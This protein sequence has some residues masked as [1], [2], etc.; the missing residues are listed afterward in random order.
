MKMLY[1]L[2]LCLY[3]TSMYSQTSKGISGNETYLFEKATFTL[4]NYNS[5]AE[6]NTRVITDPGLVTPEDIFYQNVFR[7]AIINNG[8]LLYC[9]LPDEKDYAVKDD[10]VKLLA[11][12]VQVP[13]K[14]EKKEP[15]VGRV[16]SG[17]LEPYT[18]SLKGGVLTISVMYVYG[19]SRYPYTLEGKL[20][21]TMI[22][23]K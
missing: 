23:Q 20:V 8:S 16:F 17:Q 19:D 5:K 6:V 21:L 18:M 3:T 10:G 2:M 9:T 1:I 7:R 15:T 14:E 4:Y 11:L 22:K 13:F 12:K